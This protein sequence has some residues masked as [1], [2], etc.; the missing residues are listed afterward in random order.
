MPFDKLRVNGR[1][2]AH[3]I[4]TLALERFSSQKNFKTRTST[5]VSLSSTTPLRRSLH[6]I[7]AVTHPHD[8]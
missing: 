7:P 8:S 4:E 1:L 2:G 3:G 5:R 6:Q